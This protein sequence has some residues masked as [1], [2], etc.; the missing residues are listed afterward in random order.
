V[1]LERHE[2]LIRW[3]AGRYRNRLPPGLE[4][5]D[6]LQEGRLALLRARKHFDPARGSRFSTYATGVLLRELSR[7]IQRWQH[8]PCTNAF[9][10][11]APPDEGV[12]DPSPFAPDFASGVIDA[13][14]LRQA[15][16]ALPEPER[17]VAILRYGFDGGPPLSY[18]A[19]GRHFGCLHETVRRIDARLLAR[20]RRTLT[21]RR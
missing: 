18:R 14:G 11:D 15:V 12:P 5:D 19:I 13:V 20:L 2:G 1:L 9:P 17:T 8:D 3:V 10:L 6:L 21:V 7:A 4:W 16:A